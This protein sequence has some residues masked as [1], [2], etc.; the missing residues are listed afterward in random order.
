MT[1]LFKWVSGILHPLLLPF[2]GAIL[3]FQ[4]GVY[5]LYPMN[6]KLYVAGLVFLTTGILPALA[7]LLLR[8]QGVV[9]D[10]DVSV[11]SQRV[12]PYAIIFLAYLGTIVLL[13]KVAIPWAIIKLYLGSLLSIVLAFLITLKWKIS[14]HTMSF[15][16]LIAGIII[17]CL[18]QQ[19]N[20]TLLL[21]ICFLLAGL[22]ASSRLYLKAHTVA[23]AASG[24]LLGALSV[25][26][27]YLLIP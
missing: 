14:A 5:V 18:Q 3:F 7:I 27:L 10:L 20:P 24:F 21:S 17:V 11:R 19:L 12:W 9:A 16:C 2:I 22:Q 23:Q 1:T 13:F 8:Q 4:A 26:S 15:G 25:T 6:Y